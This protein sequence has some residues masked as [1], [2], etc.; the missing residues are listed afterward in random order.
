MPR[1]YRC[2]V[3]AAFGWLSL[4]TSPSPN[5]ANQAKQAQ[6]A[7]SI[8]RS[9]DSIAT[10]QDKIAKATNT[11]EYQTPCSDGQYNNKSDLCAQWYAARAARDAAD[12]AF[13]ALVVGL[14]GA[15]GIVAALWLTVDSNRI[16]RDTA[17]RQ[18]RAYLGIESCVLEALDDGT[19]FIITAHLLNAGQTPA[20]K[21]R[22]MAETFGAEYPL[23]H[24]RPFLP[25]GN[26]YESPVNP[27]TK[28]SWAGKTTSIAM[29]RDME[30]VLAGKEGVYI[31]GVCEY[32]DAFNE[33]HET[34]F[35]YVFGG[36]M[37]NMGL[38]MHSAETG[39][40]AT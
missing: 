4:A 28:I 25:V 10:A 16:A 13:W 11:G 31:Q 24:Q 27:S 33:R 39:N 37:A 15:V 29:A 12:W 7:Q 19:G 20:Y 30:Y 18:L 1:G 21:V 23:K 17:K 6:P 36:R 8:N 22:L 34:R 26:G 3:I 35:R 40:T 5:N 32:F 38:I 14:V 9:L 2:I